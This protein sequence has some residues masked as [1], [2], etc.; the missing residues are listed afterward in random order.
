MARLLTLTHVGPNEN[1]P[2]VAKPDVGDLDRHRHARDQH[3]LVAPVELISLARRIVERDIGL[4]G[5]SA[6]LL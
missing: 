4:G 1:H 6:T 2:A 3:N 5:R